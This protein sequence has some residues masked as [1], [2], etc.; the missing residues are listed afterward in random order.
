MA[1]IG[2]LSI[3][4]P[5][6]VTGGMPSIWPGLGNLNHTEG[7]L[8][9]GDR[10]FLRKVG[11]GAG[12]AKKPGALHLNRCCCSAAQSRLTFC[13]PMDCSMPGFPVHH[14]LPEFAQSVMPS[15][16]LILCHPLLLLPSVSASGSFPMSWLFASGGR[17]IAASAS[18]LPVNIQG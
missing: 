7:C 16:H 4:K 17:S 12:Q 11:T 2:D 8:L 14:Q 18:I 13:D 15:N 1:P 3:Y 6:S 5:V 9:K 10:V